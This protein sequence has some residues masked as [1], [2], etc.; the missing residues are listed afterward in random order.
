MIIFHI[1]I[2]SRSKTDKIRS[3]VNGHASAVTLT[4]MTK[5]SIGDRVFNSSGA[6]R[7]SGVVSEAN[8]NRVLS[9]SEKIPVHCF[10]LWL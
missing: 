2:L 7:N 10:V 9:G 3:G 6:R 1:L 4:A 8:F 5:E